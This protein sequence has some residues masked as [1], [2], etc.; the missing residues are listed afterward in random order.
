[1]VFR[2]AEIE[3]FAEQ[4]NAHGDD[5]SVRSHW[6]GALQLKIS[7]FKDHKCSKE[8]FLDVQPS[9]KNIIYIQ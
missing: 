7:I 9:V 4:K 3:S 5:L 2:A 8:C 6:A 1:M